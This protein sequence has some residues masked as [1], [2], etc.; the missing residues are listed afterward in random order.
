MLPTAL[1]LLLIAG[2]G[3]VVSRALA[4]RL[5]PCARVA[6]TL[7]IG[8]AGVGWGTLAVCYVAELQATSVVVGLVALALTAPAAWALWRGR[9]DRIG[10]PAP[11]KGALFVLGLCVFIAALYAANYDGYLFRHGS[12]LSAD[13]LHMGAPWPV[14][15]PASV[16]LKGLTGGQ[17]LGAIAWPLPAWVLGGVAGFRVLFALDALLIATAL[18]ALGRGLLG[19]HVASACTVLIGTATPYLFQV[20]VVDENVISCALLATA[21]AV[22][23]EPAPVRGRAILV[24]CLAAVMVAVRHIMVLAL[25]GVGLAL[26]AAIPASERRRVGVRAAV[27]LALAALPMLFHHLTWFAPGQWESRYSIPG[28]VAG[29]SLPVYGHLNWP[30]G[31]DHVVRTPFQPFPTAIMFPLRTVQELGLLL[32]G[33]ATLGVW[34]FWRSSRAL[35]LATILIVLPVALALAPLEQWTKPNKMGV[36][37]CVLPVIALWGASG[38]RW[39]SQGP[40]ARRSMVLGAVVCTLGL[41][42][43]GASFVEVPADPRTYARS[44]DQE[45]FFQ[46]ED[47]AMLTAIRAEILDIGVFPRLASYGRYS[48]VLAD[49]KLLG[50]EVVFPTRLGDRAQV[51]EAGRVVELM[52]AAHK[53]RERWIDTPRSPGPAATFQE[54]RPVRLGTEWTPSWTPDVV[55]ALALR[56]GSMLFVVT[57]FDNLHRPERFEPGTELQILYPGHRGPPP[58]SATDGV[59]PVDGRRIRMDVSGLS[60]VIA[61]DVVSNSDE[62]FLVRE[63]YLGGGDELEVGPPRWL[64][65]P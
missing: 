26:L 27:S 61:I 5:E 35:G 44:A 32:A 43:L 54:G 46:T 15:S 34:S 12:C 51:A 33:A 21:L 47:P 64:Y 55:R 59:L 13:V 52:P 42:V 25:P 49:W 18:A 29:L 16:D 10:S 6:T 30:L 3:Y 38:L 4:P 36:L 56:R 41:G 24:G 57:V 53:A 14:L 48:P 9:T 11:E 39:V 45:R 60:H 17:R 22:A 19:H 7:G 2:P 50:Q 58:G 40:L 62:L 31:G 23:V 63:V 28:R 37:L 65:L 1:I 8:L 20:P